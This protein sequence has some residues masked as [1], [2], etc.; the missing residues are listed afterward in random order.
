MILDDTPNAFV[1]ENNKIIL[2]SGLLKYINSLEALIGIIAHEIGH[3]NNFHLS[4]RKQKVKDIQIID[5]IT[6]L[7]TITSAIL[8]KNPEIFLQSSIANKSN[9]QNYYSKYSKIQEREA[10]IFA[11]NRL[12][13]LKISTFGLVS[14]LKYLEKE[15]YKSGYSNDIFMFSTHPNYNDRLN[16]I[17]SFSNEKFNKIDKKIENKFLLIKA[18]IFGYTENKLKS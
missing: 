2:T 13:E 5:N 3:I 6:N 11:V 8:S 18:K 7:A 1:I 15:F 12:N 10:D 17:S 16:I 14:F 9:I 4:K